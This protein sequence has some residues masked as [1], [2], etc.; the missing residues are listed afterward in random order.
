[1]QVL[2]RYGVMIALIVLLTFAWVFQGFASIPLPESFRVA[3]SF[4]LFLVPGGLIG[5]L[6]AD[7]KQWNW[8]R[9]V[10]FG[11]PISIGLLG[12]ISLPV[13]TLNLTMHHIGFVLY[14]L[15]VV[16]ILWARMRYD[17]FGTRRFYQDIDRITLAYAGVA[18][19][20]VMV[21]AL[22]SPYTM[23]KTNDILLHSAEI[24]QY[25]SDTPLDWQEIYFDTGNQVWSRVSL[26]VWRLAQG[27]IAWTS[28]VH[29]FISQLTVSPMLI[30]YLGVSVYVSARLFNLSIRSSLLVTIT[31][32][33]FFTL[34]LEGAQAGDS[35]LD[36]IIRDKVLAGYAFTPIV[37]GVTNYVIQTRRWRAYLLFA[38]MLI[39][40]IFTH[41][42]LTGFMIMII[43]GWSVLNILFERHLRPY[44]TLILLSG[45]LFSPI[46]VVRYTTDQEFNFGE[47]EIDDDKRIWLD[48][49]SQLYAISP[50]VVG[51]ITYI[52]I[53]TVGVT[54]LV[55]SPKDRIARFHLS[56]V[57]V[58]GLA[59]IPLTAWVYGSLVSVYHINRAL[60]IL[61]QGLMTWYV[62]TTIAPPL[63]KRLSFEWKPAYT[64]GVQVIF[65][66]FSLLSVANLAIVE[67]ADF[68][69]SDQ[70][71]AFQRELIEVG[72]YIETQTNSPVIVTGLSDFI[73]A[74]S[75]VMK[76]VSFCNQRCMIA[77]TNI[78]EDDARLR[79]NFGY[80]FFNFFDGYTN[81]HRL[82]DLNDY[83]VD[84]ILYEPENEILDSLFVDYPEQF[85]LVFQT[86]SVDVIRY[87][88]QA[89]DG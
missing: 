38:L 12:L 7:D 72:D 3:I 21:F 29:A 15:S 62:V 84:Y 86:A 20:M 60:W 8:T 34:L 30:L 46:L 70:E 4:I 14:I 58:I 1:M 26:A 88:R 79:G 67:S 57:V 41:P 43:G 36:R 61:M 71:V 27:V 81:E 82:R 17:N 89:S 64:Y 78:T 63:I 54:S 37:L 40:S 33:A 35:I 24:T 6:I 28:G 11:L 55:R 68:E 59:L 45:L 74:I 23:R 5:N 65:I 73:A 2:S 83:N 69:K 51:G 32:F 85:E 39:G 47:E 52:L 18:I 56:N 31:H 22:L 10:A 87:T 49:E 44:L 80:R 19:V 9:F 53:I 76:P 77:F 25:A 48:E 42:I 16:G 13:R 75:H 66:G 50:D